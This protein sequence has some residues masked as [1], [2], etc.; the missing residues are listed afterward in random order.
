[1]IIDIV[2]SWHKLT[3]IDDCVEALKMHID[4]IDKCV[5]HIY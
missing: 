2:D 3:R 4:V 1:M 5:S